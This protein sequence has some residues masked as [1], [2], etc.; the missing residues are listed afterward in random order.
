MQSET[1]MIFVL[2]DYCEESPD[3]DGVPGVRRLGTKGAED[4]HLAPKCLME[5]QLSLCNITL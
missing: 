4:C 2:Q 5:V 1:S 3:A